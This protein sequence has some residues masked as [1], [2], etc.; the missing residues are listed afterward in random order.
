MGPATKEAMYT[1]KKDEERK[2][3][4][5]P[6]GRKGMGT[7]MRMRRRSRA[8]KSGGN[9]GDIRP[10]REVDLLAEAAV[11]HGETKDGAGVVL[12][13]RGGTGGGAAEI[14]RGNH[15]G[16]LGAQPV[17][18][19]VCPPRPLAVADVENGPTTGTSLLRG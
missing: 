2:R 7:W 13:V 3:W 11:G 16:A 8:R 10:D 14:G 15:R 18:A 17:A 12:K 1:R 4:E 6:T 19:A 5:A 9:A